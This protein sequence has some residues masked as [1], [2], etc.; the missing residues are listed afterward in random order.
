MPTVT[1]ATVAEEDLDA[2]PSVFVEGVG[3]TISLEDNV[4]LLDP[5]DDEIQVEETKVKKNS[6]RWYMEG[7]DG[8]EKRR[9]PLE[10]MSKEKME[11]KRK[12]H[13]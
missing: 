3:S 10:S 6:N 13:M 9:M 11:C 4:L 7:I 5:K 1:A 8:T 2:D 12:R